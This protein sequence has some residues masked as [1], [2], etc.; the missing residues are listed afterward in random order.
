MEKYKLNQFEKD[1]I[2]TN[3]R[4]AMEDQAGNRIEGAIYYYD[5]KLLVEE[6]MELLTPC[7]SIIDVVEEHVKSE[8]WDNDLEEYFND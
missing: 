4:L 2:H 7:N 8:I 5:K 1:L 6:V 3:I